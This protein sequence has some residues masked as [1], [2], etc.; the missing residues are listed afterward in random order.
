MSGFTSHPIDVT[1]CAHISS[2]ALSFWRDLIRGKNMQNGVH[3]GIIWRR[4][5]MTKL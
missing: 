4:R 3:P 2:S 5:H 1:I